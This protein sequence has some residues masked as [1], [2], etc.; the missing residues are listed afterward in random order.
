[1]HFFRHHGQ[2]KPRNSWN[3]ATS[4]LVFF[5]VFSF[6]CPC[7]NSSTD[8]SS[9]CKRLVWFEAIFLKKNAPK[10][11]RN[12]RLFA[13][14][15][16]SGEWATRFCS[17]VK[18]MVYP[19][20]ASVRRFSLVKKVVWQ[21]VG[22]SSVKRLLLSRCFLARKSQYAYNQCN[23]WCWWTINGNAWRFW[24]YLQLAGNILWGSSAVFLSLFQPSLQLTVHL[25]YRP[26]LGKARSACENAQ[27]ALKKREVNTV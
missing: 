19:V 23:K 15:K 21:S 18:I 22:F 3:R 1:M 4:C 11:L 27:K 6:S 24:K 20:R 12:V 10:L 2:R 14:V 26:F 16:R 17:L 5:L 13:S 25:L 7:M 8:E 9:L